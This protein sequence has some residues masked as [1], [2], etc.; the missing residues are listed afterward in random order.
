MI[1][2]LVIAWAVLGG[3][4]RLLLGGWLGL[5]RWACVASYALLVAPGWFLL[6]WQAALAA[7][8]FAALYW[9]P[10]H[11]WTDL[12]EMVKR[13]GLVIGSLWY[14]IATSDW[15]RARGW[16]PTVV[17]EFTAGFVYHLILAT[18]VVAVQ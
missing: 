6:P 16:Q 13:Y 2:L 17:A 5:P 11:L 8:A 18:V 12:W 14:L 4:W 3:L 15:I 10:G 1:T 7:H 9:L